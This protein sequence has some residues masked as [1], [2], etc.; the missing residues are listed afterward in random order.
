MGMPFYILLASQMKRLLFIHWERPAPLEE[1]LVPP[2]GGLDWR[3]PS[4]VIKNHTFQRSPAFTTAT[5]AVPFIGKDLPVVLEMR[6]QSTDH[7]AGYFDEFYNSSRAFFDLYR[8]IWDRVFEPSRPVQEAFQARLQQLSLPRQYMAVHI[9]SMYHRN[10]AHLPQVVHS[11]VCIASKKSNLPMYLA[12]DNINATRVALQY[13]RGQGL[14]AYASD[15]EEEK[16]HL[17]RGSNFLSPH[18]TDWH[19]YEPSAFYNIFVDL[20]LL[21][22]ASCVAFGIGGFGRWGA[23]LGQ[24]GCSV[25]HVTARGKTA[26][27]NFK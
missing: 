18:D 10:A 7:G 21:Q 27:C 24:T 14:I 6:H 20:L 2:A 11:A 22:R 8:P 16:L 1:F 13:A 12:T 9:R 5:R 23:I 4:Q 15:V 25:N 19:L 17:D 26:E 3:W